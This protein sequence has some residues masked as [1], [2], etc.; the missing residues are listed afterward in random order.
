MR[1]TT[2]TFPQ[3][4]YVWDCRV[5]HPGWRT[6]FPMS[7]LSCDDAKRRLFTGDYVCRVVAPDP[8]SE[9][10]G[11]CQM[12]YL[13]GSL[14]THSV[15]VLKC[16]D[17]CH[18]AGGPPNVTAGLRDLRNCTISSVVDFSEPAI[19]SWTIAIMTSIIPFS[20]ASAMWCW[21]RNWFARVS[22]TVIAVAANALALWL[23]L[24]LEFSFAKAS[25][26][27]HGVPF[28]LVCVGIS[29][30]WHALVCCANVIVLKSRHDKSWSAWHLTEGR[31]SSRIAPNPNPNPNSHPHMPSDTR[32][33][34]LEQSASHTD[35]DS[36]T[37][38]SVAMSAR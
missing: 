36:G 31:G 32:R 37:A 1:Q 9:G 4:T 38:S 19:T 21:G 3:D 30:V 33:S 35:A 11:G 2:I 26:A 7:Q 13:S 10:G 18:T 27:P 8:P 6:V 22:A 25:S 17:E 14:L 28:I 24:L 23:L 12:Q 34:G 29:L 15:P 5:A 20:C 16:D